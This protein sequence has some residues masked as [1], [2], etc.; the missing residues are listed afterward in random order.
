L[1][2]QQ[3]PQQNQQQNIQIQQL[4]LQQQ[5]QQQQQQQNFIY[6]TPQQQQ[7]QQQNIQAKAIL[8]TQQMSS[9]PKPGTPTN[10]QTQQIINLQQQQQIKA[11]PIRTA[12]PNITAQVIN[13]NTLN[14]NGQ[15]QQIQQQQNIP[16]QQQQQRVTQQQPQSSNQQQQATTTTTSTTPSPSPMDLLKC[17]KKFLHTLL[18]LA[19]NSLPEK[20]PLV[21]NLIQDLLV[22]V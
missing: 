1:K 19:N 21:R 3:H 2:T 10:L 4:Q 5:Q 9:S 11:E 6:A 14:I 17:L 22:C 15:I 8:N 13:P 20:Y 16:N 7:Q 12:T 18:D